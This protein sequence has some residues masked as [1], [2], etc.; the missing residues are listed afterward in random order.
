MSLSAAK[1]P[2]LK[3]KLLQQEKDL[4]AELEAVEKA[5]ARAGKSE[6]GKKS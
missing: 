6:K 2:S 5:K 1:M 4:M 3:D